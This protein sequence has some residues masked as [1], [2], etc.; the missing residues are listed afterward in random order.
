MK[1]I[2][3][4]AISS[5]FRMQR[6]FISIEYFWVKNNDMSISPKCVVNEWKKS[7]GTSTKVVVLM[8]LLWFFHRLHFIVG[9]LSLVFLPIDLFHK[10]HST[11]RSIQREQLIH[12]TGDQNINILC[13][14]RWFIPFIH[15]I[16]S[17]KCTV[18]G[19][20]LCN[21]ATIYRTHIIHSCSR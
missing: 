12:A 2:R 20:C 1:Q 7:V 16:S 4:Q 18:H 15:Y 11:S 17:M 13:M 10:I 5:A 14:F 3:I 9:L 19:S 21:M 6:L 8:V